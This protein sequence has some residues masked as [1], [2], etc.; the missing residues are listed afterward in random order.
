MNGSSMW[1]VGA[2]YGTTI[3]RIDNVV[4]TTDKTYT[5][6]NSRGETQRNFFET[7]FNVAFPTWEQAQAFLLD[8]L[9]RDVE[10]AQREIARA[11]AEIKKVSSYTP[12]EQV[13]R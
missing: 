9:N 13:L 6:I 3:N 10:W 2:K 7:E 4:S 5:W 1:E 12:N 11:Q 8:R